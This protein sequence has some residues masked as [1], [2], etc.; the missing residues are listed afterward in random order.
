MLFPKL[1]FSSVISFENYATESEIDATKYDLLEWMEN[2]R[3]FK[4]ENRVIHLI[5]YSPLI[6]M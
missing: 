2:D 4:R 1:Q 6:G 3:A 5:K